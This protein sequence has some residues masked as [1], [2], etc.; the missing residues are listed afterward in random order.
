MTKRDILIFFFKWKTTLLVLFLLILSFAVLFSYAFPPA[1]P[2]VATVLVE[3]NRAPAMRTD[4]APGL[5]M[6]EVLTTEAQIVLSRTVMENVVDELGLDQRVGK[7]TFV[8]QLVNDVKGTMADIGLI[9]QV[10]PREKWIARLLRQVKAK[11]VVSS[12]IMD[13]E[14]YDDDPKWAAAIINS[15]VDHYIAHHLEIYSQRG[16]ATIYQ[17]QLTDVRTTLEEKRLALAELKKSASASA[18]QDNKRELVRANGAVRE[19]LEMAYA[20]ERELLTRFEPE[21]QKVKT[22]RDKIKQFKEVADSTQKELFELEQIETR[23]NDILG[24]IRAEEVSFREIKRRFDEA[25]L[26][27]LANIDMINVRLVDYSPI[28]ARPDRSRLFFIG[29]T[30]IG[31]LFLSF[32]LVII[33]EYFDRRVSDPKLVEDILGIPGLGSIEYSERHKIH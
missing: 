26:D 5:D 28:A 1:Y 2:G 13:I 21:H 24:D 19:Q 7:K 20:N 25:V 23:I 12:N 4:F 14:Y 27:E 17:N 6:V 30:A 31:G 8:N 11:P 3:R 32:G 18:I 22:I 15:V 10:P 29:L 16:Q 33:F 9:Y